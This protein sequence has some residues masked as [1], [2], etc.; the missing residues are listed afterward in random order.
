MASTNL[1]F[2]LLVFVLFFN[3]MVLL[4]SATLTDEF[5]Q[6]PELKE[7]PTLLNYLSL[8]GEYILYIPSILITL[9]FTLPLY[10]SFFI[11]AI[12]GTLV[13]IG[14]QLLRGN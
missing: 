13:F 12:N 3:A 11:L 1:F 8:V 14:I 6:P 10:V 7:N 4:V 9:T 5:P 2:I